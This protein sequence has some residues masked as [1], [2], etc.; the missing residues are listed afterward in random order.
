MNAVFL[1][2]V[3]AAAFLFAKLEIEIE[4]EHGWAAKLPTWRVEKH[5]LLDLFFGGRP[6]TGYHVWAFLFVFFFFHMPFFWSPGSWTA[7]GELHSVGA[8]TLFWIV[9]DALWFVMNPHYGWKKFTKGHI[10]WHKRWLMG[11]PVD[12][13]VLGSLAAAL[14]VLP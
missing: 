9:E 5:F 14:L 13:W 2:F 3:L 1:G 12:Y 7:R 8:Y 10:W 11:L 4:G 6:L